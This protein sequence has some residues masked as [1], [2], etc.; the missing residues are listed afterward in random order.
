MRANGFDQL[1]S[2]PIERVEAGQRILEDHADAFAP[3]LAHVLRGQIV[4]PIA[5]QQDLAT[6]N[7]SRRID[8]ARDGRTGDGL[9][10]AGFAHHAQHLAARNVEGDA[11][12][13]LERAAP[14]D[15][16][17]T[18]VADRENGLCHSDTRPLIAVSD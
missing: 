18:Q 17:H 9:S 4:D 7:P 10:G 12:D 15:E 8:E 13:G 6:G 16:F 14:R 11:V 3:H 1:L 5:R 2:H